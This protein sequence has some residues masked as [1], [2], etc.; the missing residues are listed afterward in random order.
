MSLYSTL[1]KRFQVSLKNPV[2]WSLNQVFFFQLTFWN[3]NPSLDRKSRFD[4]LVLQ[5]IH[6]FFPE[7]PYFLSQLRLEESFMKIEVRAP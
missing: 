4:L 1:V 3:P 2:D 7:I 6:F 5:E